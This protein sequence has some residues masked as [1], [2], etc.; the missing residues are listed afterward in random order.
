MYRNIDASPDAFAIV[1]QHRI[2]QPDSSDALVLQDPTS[3]LPLSA[4]TCI[5]VTYADAPGRIDPP[6]PTPQPST[7]EWAAYRERFVYT[8]EALLAAQ[9]GALEPRVKNAMGQLLD[10]R[11][12][13]IR[14]I[15]R[16]AANSDPVAVRSY[17]KK[18][19]LSWELRAKTLAAAPQVARWEKQ[20]DEPVRSAEVLPPD[21]P[22]A[23][24][25]LSTETL[26]PME[27]VLSSERLRAAGNRLP[28]ASLIAIEKR[29]ATE[30][31]VSMESLLPTESAV[32][33]ESVLATEAGTD[34]SRER[35]DA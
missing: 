14:W 6:A 29:L 28:T 30:R 22:A 8:G 17:L 32:T 2:A 7:S 31:L 23:E 27:S 4:G 5:E 21:I 35:E 1:P 26:V 33:T 18:L 24:K 19:L 15:D 10:E 12:A 25:L 13:A 9:S 3:Y 11:E 34:E 20:A 16:H